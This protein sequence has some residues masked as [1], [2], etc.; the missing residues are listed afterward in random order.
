VAGRLTPG[1]LNWRGKAQAPA[2]APITAAATAPPASRAA[3]PDHVETLERWASAETGAPS[4][5]R[6]PTE[7]VLA[8]SPLDAGFDTVPL[9]A[10][11]PTSASAS[12]PMPADELPAEAFDDATER[13]ASFA[14]RAAE[15]RALRGDDTPSFLAQRT[16]TA[17]TSAESVGGQPAAAA[18]ALAV[19]TPDDGIGQPGSGQPRG[20][21]PDDVVVSAAERDSDALRLEMLAA[22]AAEGGWL[23]SADEVPAASTPADARTSDGG[24]RR[25]TV[26][27]SAADLDADA[28]RLEMLAARA[29]EWRPPAIE[30]PT[31]ADEPDERVAFWRTD[32]V[33]VSPEEFD[34]D[35]ARLETLAARGPLFAAVDAD[36]LAD[37]V[38]FWEQQERARREAEERAA[39]ETAAR[40]DA[41]TDQ[42]HA[43]WEQVAER[44]AG[45]DEH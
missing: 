28:A 29:A 3:E 17:A 22:R 41:L 33:A 30:D 23:R 35:A 13:F 44:I 9:P 21:R 25:D 24:W 2:A 19:P 32:A 45:R 39:A 20:W 15:A 7:N 14:L 1:A 16:S 36:P 10:D 18:R 26:T 27:V 31:P 38:P 37:S 5:M 8:A 4:W 40:E 34:A 6:E 43:R 12:A 42:W 11:A